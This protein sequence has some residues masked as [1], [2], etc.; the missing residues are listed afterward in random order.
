[1]ELTWRDRLAEIRQQAGGRLGSKELEEVASILPD[2]EW[3]ELIALLDSLSS[4]SSPV[5]NPLH[6]TPHQ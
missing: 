2:A 1:M 3:Q 4:T 5:V 6:C